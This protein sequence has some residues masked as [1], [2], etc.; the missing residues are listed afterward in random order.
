[1]DDPGG[2]RKN[3][4]ASSPMISITVGT[5]TKLAHRSMVAVHSMLSDSEM[6]IIVTI[7]LT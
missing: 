1:M 7:Y 3:S 4:E 2:A 5:V 6:S